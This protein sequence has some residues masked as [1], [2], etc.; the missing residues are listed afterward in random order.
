MEALSV[1]PPRD[2]VGAMEAIDEVIEMVQALLDN[3]SA[4]IVDVDQYR[5]IY[6]STSATS[7]FGYE[8]NYSRDLMEEFFAERGGDPE[9]PGKKD[10]L[11]ALIW[12]SARKGEP[13]WDAPLEQG[14]LDGI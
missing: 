2:Y 11:D 8:S 12:R 4:Y 7:H 10:P 1:I 13:S 3:G 6:A 14:A 5:D 9:R